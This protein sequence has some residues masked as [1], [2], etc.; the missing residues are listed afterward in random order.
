MSLSFFVVGLLGGQ[1]FFVGYVA[2]ISQ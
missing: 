2:Q 1:G